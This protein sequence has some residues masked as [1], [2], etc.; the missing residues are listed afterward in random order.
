MA[1]ILPQRV[2]KEGVALEGG[3]RGYRG[4]KLK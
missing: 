4:S 1:W 3:P 2:I